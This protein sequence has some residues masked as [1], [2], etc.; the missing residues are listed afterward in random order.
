MS[1]CPRSLLHL[2]LAGL[3]L[4]LG[5]APVTAQDPAAWR[6]AVDD[7]RQLAENDAPAALARAVEL[8]RSLPAD[9]PPADRVRLLN[10]QARVEGY[11]AQ[12]ERSAAHAQQAFELAEQAGDRLGLAEAGLNI[13]MND[14]NLGRLGRLQEIMTRTLAALEGADRPDLMG[15]ALLRTSM[16]YRRAN[17]L[18]DSLN[19]ALQ[20]MEIART[21]GDPTALAHAHRGLAMAYDLGDRLPEAREQFERMRAQAV[22]GR[23]RL[24]EALAISGLAGVASK[25]GDKPLALRLYREAIGL[26]QSIGIPFSEALG[27]FA[28]AFELRQQ[29][30]LKSAQAELQRAAAIYERHPNPIGRWFV[31]KEQSELAQRLGDLAEARA[32]A[33]QSYQLA[34]TID[35]PVYRSE[36]A[37]RMAAVAA[38]EGD[39]RRA[40]ELSVEAA[41]ANARLARERAGARV[42]ELAERIRSEA[43]QRELAELTRR[44]AQQVAEIERRTLQQRWQVTLLAAGA[45]LLAGATVFV[46][47]LR[48]SR[49]ELQ[50]QTVILREVLDGIGDSV[51]VVDRRAEL[52]LANPAAE[53]IAGRGMTTGPKGNWRERFGLYLPD[54]VTLCPL[55]DLPLARAL[56]GE[57]VDK[58]DLYM[59]RSGEGPDQ[60]LWLTA[61]ARPLRDAAGAV[62]GAVAVFA[63]T[64]VRRRAEEEVRALA[65]DLERRVQERT[66]ELARARQAAEAANRAK[67]EFL[68]NMSHEIRTPMNAILGMSWLALQS[69]LDAKQRNYVEKVHRA[70]ESL[71][72]VINDILDFSKIEAGRLEMEQ[73]PFRLGEV[74]DQ[75]A[76]L[77]GMRADEKGLE[78]LFD[79]PPDLPTALVGDPSRLGQVLLNL[80]NNAVK[81]TT[82][83]EVTV[84]VR[85]LSREADT[86]VLRFE[87]R[88]SGVGIEAAQRE[89]LFQPFS[90]ADAS[91]SRR[92]GGTGLG[93]AIC[94]HLVAL[95]DGEIGVD[96]TPG[97]G[98]VFHFSARFGLQPGAA[99]A[100]PAAPGE[101]R[102]ARLLIVDDHPLAREL[103]L[104]MCSSLGMQP[105][106]VGDAAAALLALRRADAD[107]APYRVLLLDWKMPG[108][109]GIELLEQLS[110]TELRHASPTVL[111]VTAFNRHEAQRRLD[112]RGLPV[113]GLLAK[114]VTASALLDACAV[115]LGRPALAARREELRHDLL[116]ARQSGL[117]GTRVLLVE[118]NEINQELACDLLRRAGIE[119]SVAADGR[120]ALDR[121]EHERFDAVLMDCQMPVMDGYE[122]TR[123]LRQW[124]GLQ[125]M[126]VI[127]MTAN[128]MAGDRERV[129]EAG[130]NDHVAKPI[131]VDELFATLSRWVRPAAGPGAAG[132]LAAVPGLDLRAGLAG[133]MGNEALYRRLLRMFHEREREFGARLAAARAAGDAPACTRLAHDLK[134]VSGTLGMAALQRAAAA[135]EAACEHGAAPGEIDRLRDAVLQQLG[136]VLDG[137]AR[138]APDLESA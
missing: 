25:Q 93:L 122:A 102:G 88:D 131:R 118:D 2:W 29:G 107:D 110:H 37:Q 98:S 67:G 39:H 105:E 75:F 7:A 24:N 21:S 20:A 40:Y 132:E 47:R 87:V 13:S 125:D 8:E 9:A 41:E 43:R 11:M 54:R 19:V 53:F 14:V 76:H 90:Q 72:V 27:H 26:Y 59:R 32:R 38:A 12:T 95:M 91:T 82:Q 136:P 52:V 61:T 138:L 44:S 126:P 58:Q 116:Q 55:E 96:S 79:L 23:S 106:A 120:A 77:V 114:P 31:L 129:L 69:G 10:L 104:A 1:R 112:E 121:L 128:A 64:S 124:P 68:A 63:D 137:L 86:V 3:L 103:M 119:V 17:L 50:R 74:L 133:V 108:T 16:T 57:D 48:R 78:L 123:V 56:R 80:G 49:T 109:D 115:A 28:L 18:D 127:A 65:A 5:A 134:S 83:G 34:R 45:L 101:L 4:C 135:L 62:S 89:R 35:L 51:L 73:I 111:M 33:E 36:S 92:Y 84:A 70:A 22:A 60:G 100:A 81:F 117:A 130:M 66:E 94:R 6:R 99:A 42:F 113:A 30:D 46:L 85:L 97:R 15:E 71:L